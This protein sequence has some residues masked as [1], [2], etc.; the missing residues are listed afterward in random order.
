SLEHGIA[1][2]IPEEARLRNDLR[3]ARGRDAKRKEA[4]LCDPEAR[5]QAPALRLPPRARRDAQELGGAEGAEPGSEGAPDGGARG[6][7]PDLLRE[8]RGRDPEGSI[9]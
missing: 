5:R 4:R 1:F 9:R 7:P 8:F 3:A 6:R 2:A